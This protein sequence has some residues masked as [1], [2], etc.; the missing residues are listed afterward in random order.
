MN[1]AS[2]TL[3]KWNSNSKKLQQLFNDEGTGCALGYVECPTA[4]VSR[5]LGLVWDKD[6]DHLAFF[7]EAILDFL[8][9]NNNSKRFILQASARIYDPLGLISPVT[10]TTK[11]MFQTL[12]ELRIEW[13]A[14]LPEEVKAAWMQW[15]TQLHHLTD[16]TVPR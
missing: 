4:S 7:M 13:N 5:V 10:V 12:W 11:L 6:S 1:R 3:R 9:R 16:V 15:H 14:P 8:S 2:M